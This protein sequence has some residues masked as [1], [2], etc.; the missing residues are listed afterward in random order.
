MS[1]LSSTRLSINVCLSLGGIGVCVL[2]WVLSELEINVPKIVLYAL[3][4]VAVALIVVP[5]LVLGAQQISR[6]RKW[7]AVDPS[8]LGPAIYGAEQEELLRRARQIAK[9][10]VDREDWT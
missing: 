10:N 9:D 5:W 7:T 4:V 8:R 3:L 2:L 1:V 6:R